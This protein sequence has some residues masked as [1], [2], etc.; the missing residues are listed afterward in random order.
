MNK[1]VSSKTQNL[2]RKASPKTSVEVL[3]AWE[4]GLVPEG[5]KWIRVEGL[6]AELQKQYDIE[7]EKACDGFG[8]TMTSAETI[9][10]FLGKLGA[11]E[12]KKE[13]EP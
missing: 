10:W 4:L 8:Y 2:L 11:K 5:T 9:Q 1:K 12:Q 13:T 3:K 6:V 7:C